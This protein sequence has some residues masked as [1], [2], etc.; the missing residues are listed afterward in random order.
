[1]SKWNLPWLRHKQKAITCHAGV[2]DMRPAPGQVLYLEPEYDQALNRYI[3]EHRPQ[4]DAGL[5]RE[6]LTLLYAPAHRYTSDEVHYWGGDPAMVGQPACSVALYRAMLLDVPLS[7]PALCLCDTDEDDLILFPIPDAQALE[8]FVNEGAAARDRHAMLGD[9]PDMSMLLE[10][11]EER[12]MAVCGSAGVCMAARKEAE[13]EVDY[14]QA[15]LTEEERQLLNE[16][17]ERLE[18]LRQAGISDNLLSRL[19]TPR[20]EVSPLHITRDGHILLPAYDCEI[21]LAGAD[22]D[23]YLLLLCHPE[24]IRQKC[25][26]DYIEEMKRLHLRVCD[27]FLTDRSATAIQ[28]LALSDTVCNQRLARI[29]N[30]FLS[31]LAP[32]LAQH[33]MPTTGR[34]TPRRIPLPTR[35]IVWEK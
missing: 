19:L 32:P 31:R 10:R 21:P 6:G 4:L 22:R 15:L 30:A 18:K 9:M 20:V 5:A 24:G 13:P 7:G 25:L 1:M 12:S 35:L 8:R 11:T 17:E 14:E 29:R 27:G 3:L 2:A 26:T 23:L 33:Y 28:T 34:D 16:V